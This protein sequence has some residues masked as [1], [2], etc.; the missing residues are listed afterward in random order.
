LTLALL[1]MLIR[2][3]TRHK[4]QRKS[5]SKYTV[6]AKKSSGFQKDL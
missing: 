4:F 1:L 5:A 2:W 3:H 6:L